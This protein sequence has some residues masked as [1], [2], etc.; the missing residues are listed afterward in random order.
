MRLARR[1][2]AK[3]EPWRGRSDVWFTRRAGRRRRREGGLPLPGVEPTFAAGDLDLPELGRRV[4][5]E[6]PALV[7]DTVAPSTNHAVDPHPRLGRL[8][9]PEPPPFAVAWTEP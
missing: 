4:G 6:A 2:L 9:V 8:D 5:L 1:L 7:G 3:G